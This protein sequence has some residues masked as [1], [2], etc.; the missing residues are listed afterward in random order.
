M[1]KIEFNFTANLHTLCLL[2]DY[3]SSFRDSVIYFLFDIH[4][5]PCTY[6]IT[7]EKSSLF[8]DIQ[9]KEP[10]PESIIKKVKT[11]LPPRFMS[12]KEAA[13]QLLEL[14]KS[15]VTKGLFFRVNLNYII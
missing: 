7:A 9:V 1:K 6:Y 12:V 2:G 13:S 14:V 3:D 5:Q 15:G 8:L 11:Y 10:I 4:L